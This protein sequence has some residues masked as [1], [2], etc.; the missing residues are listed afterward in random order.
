MTAPL[1]AEDCAALDRLREHLRGRFSSSRVG[2][3]TCEDEWRCD[4]D[5][6]SWSAT[7]NVRAFASSVGRA[8]T[9]GEALCAA[10]AAIGV[11]L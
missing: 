9:A 4:I 8:P 7:G 3:N 2:L 10:A 11:A 5:A 1:T 6:R